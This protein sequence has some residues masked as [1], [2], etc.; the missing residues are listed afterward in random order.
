MRRLLLVIT[1]WI[2]TGSQ[3]LSATSRV[4]EKTEVLIIGAGLSGMATAYGLKKAGIAYHILEIAPRVGGR[5]RTVSYER[6]GMP[7]IRTDSGMEEYWESNPAVKVLK[8]L[9]LPMSSDM[10]ASSIVISK[11]FYPLGG[12]EPAAFYAKIFSKEE[13]AALKNFKTKVTPWIHELTEVQA[14]F[15]PD[16]HPIR[17]DLMKLK[18]ISFAKFISDEKVP[19]KVAEWIRIS[20]ECEIGTPW[21][22]ISALDGLAEFHIF[23]GDEGEKCYRVK[24]GNDQFTDGMA[25]AI[26]LQH[27]SVN[28][29]VTRIISNGNSV[30]VNYLDTETNGNGVIKASHVV[31]TIPLFRLF[32]VQFDP[33][34]S[35]K[36]QQAIHTMTWGAYFKV[37][38][39]LN[40]NA[41]KFWTL[42]G[43]NTLPILTDSDLGVIYDGNPAK[44][45]DVRMVSLLIVADAAERFNLTPLDTVRKQVI[46]GLEKMW[47]G[48]AK[49]VT[50][51][52]FY[53][54]HPRAIASW[55]VGRS[56]FDDLSNEIRKPENNVYMAG[57]FTESSHSDGAFISAARVVKQIL[58]TR[59]K[60]NVTEVPGKK[61]KLK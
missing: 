14:D 58:E 42:N 20:L 12:E 41:E 60:N 1:A 53:R 16:A 21:D 10:A 17:A 9:K 29:R 50:D 56:R 18:D 15:K 48:F 43:N 55:P 3:I 54:Y 5:V 57:D 36:K 33:P 46:D 25:K 39:F 30:T 37:H 59:L 52:E 6:P 44:K 27:I 32:E 31:N 35:E 34:L 2:L 47:P 4:P 11:Q 7:E 40:K 26:G 8:E 61:G 22:R 38:I 49:E 24:G 28:K 19:V 51:V 45:G 23:L 13:W